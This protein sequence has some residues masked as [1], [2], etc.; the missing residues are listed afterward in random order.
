MLQLGGKRKRTTDNDVLKSFVGEN[1]EGVGFDFGHL[2][3]D[4]E[5]RRG[6]GRIEDLISKLTRTSANDPPVTDPKPS[7]IQSI[8]PVRRVHE[9]KYLR[10]AGDG[11]RACR[12][13]LVGSCIATMFYESDFAHMI[14]QRPDLKFKEEFSLREFFTPKQEQQIQ[15]NDNTLPSERE[16]CLLCYRSDVTAFEFNCRAENATVSSSVCAS[17][18]CNFVGIK[19]EYMPNHVIVSLPN[20]Y[21]GLAAPIVM[22]ARSYHVPIIASGVRCLQCTLPSP[23]D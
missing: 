5:E 8:E 15:Q 21:T 23:K 11:E 6:T 18:F 20:R 17:R 10:E 1:M 16:Q 19:Q 12:N 14:A 7:V 2:I 22:S 4:S 3:S 13:S 9:E